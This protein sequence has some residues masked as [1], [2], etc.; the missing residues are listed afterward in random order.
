MGENEMN[1]LQI[2]PH[3]LA[4]ES[5]R[6]GKIRHPDTKQNSRESGSPSDSSQAFRGQGFVIPR[7]TKRGTKIRR[8]T[9]KE[10]EKAA[11]DQVRVAKEIAARQAKFH[12]RGV[13]NLI[14]TD[15]SDDDYG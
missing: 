7:P 10:L 15:S 5:W 6:K 11:Q 8:A 1:E 4:R 13:R 2:T 12:I 9:Q 3:K 14:D